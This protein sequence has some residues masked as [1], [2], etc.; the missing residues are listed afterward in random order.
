VVYG[1]RA[2]PDSALDRSQPGYRVLSGRIF[3]GLLRGLGL[4]SERDTQ[5]GLK[6]FSAAATEVAIA[7][8]VTERFAFDV[9]ALARAD[10]AGLRVQGLPVRW[11]HVEASRVRPIHDGIEMSRAALR[12]RRRLDAERAGRV[13]PRTPDDDGTVEPGAMAVDA[14]EAMAKVERAHWWFRA[15]HLLVLDELARHQVTGV[16]VDVGSGTGGLLERLRQAGHRTV[17]LE[18][19]PV[20]LHHAGSLV[21]RPALV[22]SVAEAVPVRSAGAAAAT[23]LDV[24]EHLDDDVVALQELAR[25]VGPGGLVVVAVPAYPWAWSDHDVRLG[26]R[27]RYTRPDLLA[28]A[29][30]AGLDVQRCTHFHS[31]LAPVAWVVR[32][33]PVRHLLGSGSAE[34]A[35]FGN[36]WINRALQAVTDVERAALRSTDL[37]VGLSILLVA[38]VP[39]AG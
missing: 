30:S 9:E 25:T 39:D 34:E 27:R 32:R 3:N 20:A 35:S 12:I 10:R 26:H 33:T 11:S 22:R 7:P 4:T 21:P 37:P 24:I 18:L 36:R 6:G 23:A 1:T 2:H 17:G 19:D 5:C 14:I 29:R 13:A 16:V 31:W 8:L 28:A 38:R 15:K